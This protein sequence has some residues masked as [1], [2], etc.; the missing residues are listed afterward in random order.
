[1]PS[2]PV[3]GAAPC[4]R[5][6]GRAGRLARTALADFIAAS[7]AAV[8]RILVDDEAKRALAGHVRLVDRLFKAILPDPLV[9]EFGS[10]RAVLVYLSQKLVALDPSVDV[11]DVLARV[12]RLLDASVAANAYVIEAP[13]AVPAFDLHEIDW[14]A[15]PGGSPSSVPATHLRDHSEP[16]NAPGDASGGWRYPWLPQ[17][18]TGLLHRSRRVTEPARP[19]VPL[20]DLRC[21][22]GANAR[23]R[24]AHEAGST[25]LRDVAGPRDRHLLLGRG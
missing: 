3:P 17:P 19:V 5:R 23:G 6:T 15:L 24:H 8:E 12:E 2:T 13:A 25:R 22:G 20:P 9:N 7:D 18:R 14:E 1:L 4:R 11:T 16:E 10:L 21:I